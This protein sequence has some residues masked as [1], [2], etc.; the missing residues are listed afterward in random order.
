[1]DG[2]SKTLILVLSGYLF[3]YLVDLHDDF[4]LVFI[5]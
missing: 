2:E 1:M 5:C 4:F 3:I